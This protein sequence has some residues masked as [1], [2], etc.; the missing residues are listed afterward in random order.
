MPGKWPASGGTGRARRPL[1]IRGMAQRTVPLGRVASCCRSAPRLVPALPGRCLA[2][3][4]K[5]RRIGTASVG[6]ADVAAGGDPSCRRDGRGAALGDLADPRTR[7]HLGGE[8]RAA[9]PASPTSTRRCSAR[10]AAQSARPA[11][12]R[13]GQRQH[14]AGARS[15]RLPAEAGAPEDRSAF[16]AFGRWLMPRSAAALEHAV[17]GACAKRPTPSTWSSNRSRRAAR[18]AWAARAPRMCSCASCRCR[19]RSAAMPG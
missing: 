4:P 3:T 1:R 6:P 11:H 13:L 18:G 9:A 15:A 8:C 7:P 14:E 17:A 2:Q 12:R 19:R 10:G 16:L 5:P